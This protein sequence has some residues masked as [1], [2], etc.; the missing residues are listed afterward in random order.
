MLYKFKGTDIAKSIIESGSNF[1][2]YGDPDIDG[3]VAGYFV[4]AY[5]RNRG[6]T[7]SYYINSNRRH[8]FTLPMEKIKG[9]TIIAVD[10]AMTENQIE[11]VVNSD[12]NIVLIDH[13]NTNSAN[14]IIK[15]NGRNRGILINNQYPFEDSSY[16]FL[17]GAG[18]V[19]NVLG[20]IN[21]AFQSEDN[22]ALVGVT[23]LSDVRE[24]ENKLAQDYLSTTYKANT[25]MIS[26]LIDITKPEYNYSFGIPR[27]DRQF[28]DY[29]F[30][31]RFN[32]MF[33]ANKGYEAFEFMLGKPLSRDFI[34][35]CRS[36]Q[37]TVTQYI[38]NNL[39]GEEYSDLICKYIDHKDMRDI[40]LETGSSPIF[41]D[42]EISNFIG[43]VASRIKGNKSS[44]V[45]IKNGDII[46]RGSFRGSADHNYLQLFRDLGGVADGHKNAFGFHSMMTHTFEE[47]NDILHGMSQFDN[48]GNRVIEASNLSTIVHTNNADIAELNI[49]RRSTKQVF[50]KY[51]GSKSNC[52][53]VEKGKMVEWR[54]DGVLVKAFD[55]AL[56][57]WDNYILPYK[58]KGYTV[59]YLK[60]DIN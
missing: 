13:H 27:M 30:S 22:K 56:N 21:P 9:K 42:A 7:F 26:R 5:L 36:F 60:K 46:E 29:T 1:L 54:V 45:Y 59:F 23:L 16:R 4:C 38:L 35:E 15:D 41:K 37:N 2:V 50:I 34:E 57:P 53:F 49:Y 28:I 40:I 24:I 43:L 10:F 20:C 48:L 8:G 19:Y 3:M 47:F 31:P 17:S 6:T 51:L 58:D 12:A 25:P 52:T 32:A 39:K 14:M 11:E 18:V 44:M 33:R 55:K